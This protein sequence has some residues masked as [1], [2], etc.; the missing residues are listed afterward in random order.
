MLTSLATDATR[1]MVTLDVRNTFNLNNWNPIPESLAKIGVPVYLSAM[2]TAIYK[3][4][5]S[6]I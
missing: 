3:N 2:S 1:G 4:G 5:D 6:G